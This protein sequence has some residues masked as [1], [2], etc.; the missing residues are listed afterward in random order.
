MKTKK[1]RCKICGHIVRDTPP[2]RMLHYV[3]SHKTE[4]EPIT[5]QKEGSK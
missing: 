1:V 2:D 4:G 5:E 3:V